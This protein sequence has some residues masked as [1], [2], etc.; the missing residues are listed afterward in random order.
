MSGAAEPFFAPT[1][2]ESAKSQLAESE[3]TAEKERWRKLMGNAD[4][5]HCIWSLLEDSLQFRPVAHTDPLLM[6]RRVGVRDFGLELSNSLRSWCPDLLALAEREA[7]DRARH[8][9]SARS[10]E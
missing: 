7:N 10:H 6:Q 8:R 5:R 9:S 4:G 1:E 2:Q 3:A